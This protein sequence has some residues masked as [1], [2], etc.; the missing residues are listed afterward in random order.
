VPQGG[1]P[2]TRS[3]PVWRQA[4]FLRPPLPIDMEVFDH[5]D[6]VIVLSWHG[7]VNMA[8]VPS[9]DE[10]L[11]APHVQAP[12]VSAASVICPGKHSVGGSVRSS[13]LRGLASSGSCFG[14]RSIGPNDGQ[15]RPT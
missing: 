10:S 3:G 9:L 1:M 11:G 14:S 13:K 6:N 5:E 7:F 2:A 12:C 4:R 15:V 8:L